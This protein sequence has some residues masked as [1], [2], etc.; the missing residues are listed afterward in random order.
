MDA[1]GWSA[2]DQQPTQEGGGKGSCGPLDFL[3]LTL[4]LWP[5]SD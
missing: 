4:K 5:M 1:E 3:H 2:M